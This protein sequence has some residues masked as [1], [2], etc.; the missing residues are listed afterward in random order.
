MSVN[1]NAGI[2]W[3]RLG[4]TLGLIG[5]VSAVFLFLTVNRFEGEL[6]RIGVVAIGSVAVVTAIT[7]F[8]IALGQAVDK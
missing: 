7:G 5:F 6:L 3:G 1:A 8:I 4:R 2:G